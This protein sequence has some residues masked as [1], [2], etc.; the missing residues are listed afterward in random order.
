MV[1]SQGQLRVHAGARAGIAGPVPVS[2]PD[3]V[4]VRQDAEPT[5]LRGQIDAGVV[6]GG[7][8]H[9][10]GE[11]LAD[12][13]VGD[14]VDVRPNEFVELAVRFTDY[15]GKYLVHCH[16][17]EHEDMAMLATYRTT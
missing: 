6:R 7:V 10:V 4:V 1:G 14:T 16:N 13:E 11:R 3:T 8:L 5:V 12:D 9:D 2:Q 17:L 15:R